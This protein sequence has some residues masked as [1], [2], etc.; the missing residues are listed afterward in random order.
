[1]PFG[2]GRGPIGGGR[3]GGGGRGRMGGNRPGAGPGGNCVC[4]SCGVRIPH[5]VGV[6]CYSLNCPKCG[7]RMVR[8]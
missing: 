6:P 8:G 4:P 1:M 5:Q 3:G 7:T 2:D